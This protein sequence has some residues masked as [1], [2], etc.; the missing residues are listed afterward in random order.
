MLRRLPMMARNPSSG[1][2]GDAHTLVPLTKTA[3]RLLQPGFTLAA[4]LLC[5]TKAKASASPPRL[6]HFTTTEEMRNL[7]QIMACNT[8]VTPREVH[9]APA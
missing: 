6:T 5:M 1:K 4:Q 2:T 7:H 9:L 3:A 8:D